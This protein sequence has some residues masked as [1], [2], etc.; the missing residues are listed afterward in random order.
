MTQERA[1]RDQRAA[2]PVYDCGLCASHDTLGFQFVNVP[3]GLSFHAH[4]C[5]V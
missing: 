2:D 1:H 5:N 3:N 4:T